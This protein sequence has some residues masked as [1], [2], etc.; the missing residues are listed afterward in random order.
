MSVSYAHGCCQ[1]SLKK[2]RQQ[3]LA[4]RVDEA[5]AYGRADLGASWAAKHDVVLSQKRGAGWWLWKPYLILKTLKDPSVPWHRGVV[6]WVD[7]GNYLHNDPRPLL[8][9]ALE[10][11][12]VVA[13]RL[14]WCLEADWT[15]VVTLQ[16]LNV[17]SK[18]SIVDRPQLGAYFLAFRKTELSIKFVEEWLRLC[19]DPA[20]LLG[21]QASKLGL[22]SD[23]QQNISQEVIPNFQMHQADQS[24]FSVLFKEWGFYPVSLEEGHKVVTLDRWRE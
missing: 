4:V 14:K 6:L 12:D 22:L 3:A 21:L 19:E 10:R 18:Y 13:F 9:R 1:K 7:A 2:N 17:S 16:R 24:V 15:S 23:S 20:T 8:M 5:R 11:S